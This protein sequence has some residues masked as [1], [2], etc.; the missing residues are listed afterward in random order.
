MTSHPPLSRLI[1]YAGIPYRLLA[2]IAGLLLIESAAN[3]AT[4]LIIGMVTAA[5][6][7]QPGYDFLPLHQLI[8]LWLAL[9]L[10]LSALGYLTAQKL[11]SA[12]AQVSAR[13]RLRL[14]EHIQTLP[15]HFF[16]QREHGDVLSLLSEDI[17]RVSH[18][19]VTTA[20]QVTPHVITVIGATLIVISIDP[21]TGLAAL[22]VMPLVLI[23][24][25]Q[26]GRAARPLSRTLAEKM[27]DHS[28]LTEE[29]LRLNQLIKA[30]TREDIE[31]E[32]YK[33]SNQALLDSEIRHLTISNRIQPLVEVITSTAVIAL[34]WL[35]AQRIQSG[36]L[37]PAELVSLIMYGF[38][39]F[40]PLHAIG[41]TYSGYQ[42]ALGAAGRL[43]EILDEQRE[44]QETGNT[45]LQS[46]SREIRFDNIH[47]TYPGRNRTLTDFN[48]A[49]PA[50]KVTVLVGPNG[51]G[52]TT[53]TLLLLRFFE[54]QQGNIYIDDINIRD[55]EL[56]ELRARISYVPQ[57]VTLINGTIRDNIRYGLAD[58]SNSEILHAAEKALVMDFANTLQDG[59]ETQV[60][61]GGVRLSGGQKQRIS[62]ARA[63][64][65]QAPIIVLD[66]P[67]AMF[68][69]DSEQHLMPQLLTLLSG[70]TVLII[71]HRPAMLEL[72]DKLLQL[73]PTPDNAGTYS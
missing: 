36:E 7:E 16:Q 71:T 39:L 52:K 43:T 34:V 56:Y 44:P 65:K 33:S 42:S 23:T 31:L 48:A 37:L 61:P 32:R 6:L 19:L 64:L 47:F 22:C 18:F 72:A 46:P 41:I 13:L 63:L 73:A 45:P 26:T 67:T 17:Q 20:T 24:I 54:P 49:F 29:N 70:K 12:A 5:I 15:T 14:Y 9:A 10:L 62:L 25:R 40:R 53:L 8:P 30:F 69:P 35:G 3:L 1:R 50:G 59:L 55:I 4:P 58:A 60:G 66:E 27:A 51:T 38:L 21:L 28:S 57:N 2:G 68:D 11:G